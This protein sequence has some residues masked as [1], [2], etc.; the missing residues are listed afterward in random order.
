LIPD[1]ENSGLMVVLEKT[2]QSSYI[3]KINKLSSNTE[4]IEKENTKITSVLLD[5]KNE[6]YK[7]FSVQDTED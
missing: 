7:R 5:E 3:C 1:D 4:W 6:F 2:S